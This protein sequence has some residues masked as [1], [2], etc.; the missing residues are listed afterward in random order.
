MS[1]YPNAAQN[2]PVVALCLEPLSFRIFAAMAE[3]GICMDTMFPC[4]ELSFSDC[5]PIRHILHLECYNK[6]LAT[7]RGVLATRCPMCRQFE[8]GELEWISLAV[9]FGFEYDDFDELTD[10]AP[11]AQSY[12]RDFQRGVATY[13]ELHARADALMPEDSE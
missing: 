13:A 1:N 3:C 9:I 11:G 4:Q 10:L 2:K 12:A 6:Y 5:H 7:Q 8:L